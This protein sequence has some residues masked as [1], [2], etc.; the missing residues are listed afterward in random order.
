MSRE[1]NLRPVSPPRPPLTVRGGRG[2]LVAQL[3]GTTPRASMRDV[4]AEEVE[5]ALAEPAV[6][7][8]QLA[9]I[10]MHASKPA[11]PKPQ[12]IRTAP[13]VAQVI[14][15]P[16]LKVRLP[17]IPEE[18]QQL[19][20]FWTAPTSPAAREVELALQGFKKQKIKNRHWRFSKKPVV[21]FMIAGLCLAALVV[22]AFSSR[23][24]LAQQN[25]LQNSANA[26]ENLNEAKQNLEAF[27]FSAAADRFA[28]AAD[29]FDKA[30][31][32]LS[33]LGASFLSIF[34]NLPGIRKVTAANKLVEAGH[35]ISKAGENLALAFSSLY[36]I[37]FLENKS[38][39]K[40]IQDFREVLQYSNQRISH[41]NKLLA[42]INADTIPE[43]KR[44]LFEEFRA[45]IPDFKNYIGQ[46]IEYSDYLISIVGTDAPKTYVML[47][48]NTGERR[49]TGGFPGTY[50]VMAFADGT[51]KKLFVDDVYNI[52][53]QIKEN[54]IPPAP[55]VHITPNL[56]MRD[57]NWFADFPA[58][59]RKIE[60][61]YRLDGGA[62]LDG[63]FAVTPTV[64]ARILAII[65]PVELSEHNVT[66][67]SDN[68][69]ALLQDQ[70]EYKAD[71]AQPKKIIADFQPK[72][73]EKIASATKDQW[74]AIMK[75]LL[76]SVAEKH[77][78]AYFNDADLQEQAVKRGFGGELVAT[79][80]DYLQVN[81][82]NVRGSKSD[83]VTS[84]KM[85]LASEFLPDSLS[86]TLTVTRIHRGGSS[87]YGFY[88]KENPAYVKVYLPKG[89]VFDGIEGNSTPDYKPLID[90]AELGFKEDSEITALEK[91]AA[92]PTPGVDVFEETGKTVIGYWQI[93]KPQRTSIATLKYHIP[94]SALDLQSDEYK[95]YWQKQSGSE[96]D[97]IRWTA[98][99]PA[100]RMLATRDPSV[101][102]IGDN[103]I[104][105]AT[106]DTD[107]KIKVGFE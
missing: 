51:L 50:A 30:S 59:A 95:L 33:N 20:Q 1:V 94:L 78:I 31:S 4:I 75:V 15:Q 104:F 74:L 21:G 27:N 101:Q 100:D 36:K 83:A 76:Q 93:T 44:K 39:A 19:K 81:F 71:R 85:I 86:Q 17:D 88:N 89:A 73:F 42:A 14:R 18:H 29:D 92:H 64:I 55:L 79:D 35:D 48:Q 49:P 43:D 34:G 84:N 6:S 13:V 28:L 97:T 12:P 32:T 105:D 62:K 2:G 45:K 87:P 24:I 65:G 57:A 70:V 60:E 22:A 90:F 47:L 106:L 3:L 11:K 91:N 16:A 9:G 107:Q 56:G 53:G 8:A 96:G 25:V 41:A 23:G 98:K 10:T 26:V 54:R 63:V 40:P 103:L 77:V 102:V 82:S 37:S 46:A 5:R 52:D 61:Y 38:I 99:V 72:F 68:F 7:V 67:A 69:M 66:L 58:S 80:S